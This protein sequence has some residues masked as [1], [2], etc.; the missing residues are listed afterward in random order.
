MGNKIQKEM[1]TFMKGEDATILLL[2]PMHF[3]HL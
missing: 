1:V 2:R 3:T